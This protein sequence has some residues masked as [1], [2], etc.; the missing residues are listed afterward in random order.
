MM[1]VANGFSEK[2]SAEWC[3]KSARAHNLLGVLRSRVDLME[4]LNPFWWS[5]ALVSAWI[6]GICLTLTLIA[7]MFCL[8]GRSRGRLIFFLVL[9]VGTTAAALTFGVACV[10]MESKWP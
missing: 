4:I 5:V 3:K 7:G 9:L 6:A 10:M 1:D 8:V 2:L